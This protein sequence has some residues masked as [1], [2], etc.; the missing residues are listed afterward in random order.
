MAVLLT[1]RGIKVETIDVF[2]PKQKPGVELVDKSVRP[3]VRVASVP[4]APPKG[5]FPR[6][7]MEVMKYGR[8]KR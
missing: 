8:R 3:T 5:G 7:A 6:G 1:K 2:F 4:A